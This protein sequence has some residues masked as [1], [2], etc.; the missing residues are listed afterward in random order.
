MLIQNCTSRQFYLPLDVYS[1]HV[2]SSVS[3]GMFTGGNGDK[4]LHRNNLQHFSLEDSIREVPA[5]I[6]PGIP[7]VAEH[8]IA[9]SDGLNTDL[10]RSGA[11]LAQ[12]V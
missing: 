9:Q 2:P 10:E 11:V 3:L 4:F 1:S 8:F 12:D 7:T 5:N 6:Q